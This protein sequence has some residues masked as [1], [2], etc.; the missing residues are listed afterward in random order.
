D[1]RRVRADMLLTSSRYEGIR[2]ALINF[3][4]AGKIRNIQQ[5]R[6]GFSPEKY[7]FIMHTMTSKSAHQW[8]ED[9]VLQI[10]EKLVEALTAD[11]ALFE[12]LIR[13]SYE[14]LLQSRMKELYVPT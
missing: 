11:Y 3:I 5:E 14:D 8:Q 9:I 10:E 12:Q 7:A 6:E 4:V 2:S 13:E 1:K